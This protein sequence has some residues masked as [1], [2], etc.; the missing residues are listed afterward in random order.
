[1]WLQTTDQLVNRI[2]QTNH[3]VLITG[4][5]GTGKTHMAKDIH[6]LSSRKEKSFISINLATL[7]ENLIES[8][9]FGHEKGSFSGADQKRIGKLELGA[10]GT[11]FLDEIGELSPRLQTKLLDALNHKVIYAVGS[12]REVKLDVRII[13]ATNRDL[14]KMVTAGTFREDLY[15]RL[16]TFQIQLP[17][18][19]A[20]PDRIIE[21]AQDFL[22]QTCTEQGSKAKYMDFNYIEKLKTYNWPGNVRELKNALD[23]S[24]AISVDDTL[25]P[26]QLPPYIQKRLNEKK[27]TVNELKNNHWDLQFPIDYR[28]AK[29]QF[30]KNYLK[31][32]LIHFNGKVNLTARS[33]NISKVTLIEKIRRYE[34]NLE[35]IKYANYQTSTIS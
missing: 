19:A 2:A 7:N 28:I 20:Q 35:E 12:N 4:K 24:V 5:T 32:M 17:D 27:S 13:A 3:T 31:E 21:L 23:F 18:L 8:E 1:M 22:S 15:Y 34:I 29:E 11:V 14:E 9:L 25:R 10:G 26:E 6:C 33:T 30:E 16:N